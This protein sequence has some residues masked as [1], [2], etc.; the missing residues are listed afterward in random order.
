MEEHHAR[1]E[2]LNDSERTRQLRTLDEWMAQMPS[3]PESDVEHELRD[4]RQSRRAGGRRT[5]QSSCAWE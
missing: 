5:D 3:K 1:L 2:K 4:I